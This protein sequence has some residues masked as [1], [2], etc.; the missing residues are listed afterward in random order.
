LIRF[1]SLRQG[2]SDGGGRRFAG[3][4]NVR[5]L[6]RQS[7]RLSACRLGDTIIE[8]VGPPNTIAKG[9]MTVLTGC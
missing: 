8:G 6:C 5:R 9:P 1:L 2:I 7:L 4:A 3:G